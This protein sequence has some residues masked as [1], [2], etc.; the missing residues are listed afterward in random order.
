MVFVRG[1]AEAFEYVDMRYAMM[2]ER[3]VR[4]IIALEGRGDGDGRQAVGGDVQQMI[5][6]GT[7]SASEARRRP[8][9]GCALDRVAEHAVDENGCED[10]SSRRRRASS[11]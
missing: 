8:S 11:V 4:N 1:A 9:A 10:P 7:T 2:G 6:V 5:L 3:R